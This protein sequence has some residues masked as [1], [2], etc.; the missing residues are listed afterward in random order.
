MYIH[1]ALEK[2]IGKI[3]FLKKHAET[4][5]S[6]LN[7]WHFVK[8]STSP[9]ILFW[10]HLL[11]FARCYSLDLLLYTFQTSSASEHWPTFFRSSRSKTFF[12]MGALKNFAIFTKKTLCSSPFLITLQASSPAA[13][14]KRDF[15]TIVFLQILRIL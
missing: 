10:N 11:I 7:N 5:R 1:F 12:K 4:L 3:V 8:L 14:L 9:K 13:S 15:N 2:Q 6:I